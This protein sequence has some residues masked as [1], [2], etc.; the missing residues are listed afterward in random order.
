MRLFFFFYHL[1]ID[2]SS[3]VVGESVAERA[4]PRRQ[5]VPP[6]RVMP[7]P[8]TR[9]PRRRVPSFRFRVS[10]PAGLCL[11]CPCR[12]VTV[13]K[14]AIVP[15]RDKSPGRRHGPAF[16]SQSCLVSTLS[17]YKVRIESRG[18]GQFILIAHRAFRRRNGSF[19]DDGGHVSRSFSM[20][21]RFS[22]PASNRKAISMHW[23]TLPLPPGP[24]FALSHGG[25]LLRFLRCFR[26]SK[27][28]ST[29]SSL[30]DK[31][32]FRSV[33]FRHSVCARLRF[34]RG[35]TYDTTSIILDFQSAISFRWFPVGGL[36]VV[37]PMGRAFSS[38][39]SILR[40]TEGAVTIQ[41]SC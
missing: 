27:S 5:C 15:R 40:S 34:I 19:D 25:S 10:D 12:G 31:D 26:R 37:L 41:K 11:C 30:V 29:A 36:R 32:R 14:A 24:T 38:I 22:A 6:P 13:K 9:S 21:R 20:P 8:A 7:S 23:N 18:A 16:K 35:N 2:W 33:F 39:T 4:R 1:E 28:S 17:G 3:K